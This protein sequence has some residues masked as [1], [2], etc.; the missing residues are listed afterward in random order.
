MR[1]LVVS[2]L[3]LGQRGGASVLERRLPRERLLAVLPQFDRLVLLGDIVE[4]QT[5]HSDQAFPVAEPILRELAAAFGQDKPI[6][7]VPGNHDHALIREWSAA[8]GESL[9]REHLVPPDA[10][11]LLSEMLSWLGPDRVEVRY[12]GVWLGPRVWATHGHYLNYYLRP[13][14]AIGFL[15]PRARQR[16]PHP[17]LPGGYEH[18]AEA[19]APPHMSD[20]LPPQRWHDRL[21][22]TS[23]APLLSQALGR[24]MRHHSL[25]ALAQTAHA[26]GVDAGWVVFGHVHR[27]GPMTGEDT[28][29]W[30]GPDGRQ[31]LLNTGSWRFEPVISHRTHPPHPYWPGGAV[32]I[33]DD[34]QPECVG[35]LDD[36]SETDFR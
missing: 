20:G 27:R 31:R 24:Q 6:L 19:P 14:S 1:T 32:V 11:P 10:S 34:D 29:P 7:L 36:L 15:H 9:E 4:M 26:L 17:R 35:L 23:M 30:T 16:L 21:F 25:P 8:Q 13:V 33:H 22:P 2:D 3:H 12:P 28:A 18:V 5:V